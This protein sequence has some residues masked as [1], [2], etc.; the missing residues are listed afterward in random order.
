MCGAHHLLSSSLSASHPSSSARLQDLG[1][2]SGLWKKEGPSG[3]GGRHGYVCLIVARL[4]L[5]LVGSDPEAR[6]GGDIHCI[7]PTTTTKQP[8]DGRHGLAVLPAL[9]LFF[10]LAVRPGCVVPSLNHTSRSQAPFHCPPSHFQAPPTTDLQ[11]IHG[12]PVSGPGS[13]DGQVLYV[14]TTPSCRRNECHPRSSLSGWGGVG[15][16]N[17]RG[18]GRDLAVPGSWS[19]PCR[20]RRATGAFFPLGG[21]AEKLRGGPG[22]W[23]TG[24]PC[25]RTRIVAARGHFL[26]TR[27][28]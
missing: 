21:G 3:E 19:P 18:I 25:K 1:V 11:L 24:A 6:R 17:R 26:G 5:C 7:C 28:M 9:F 16:S 15:R 23:T 20:R 27:S 2:P 14:P 13:T 22:R 4:Q 8:D 10:F 12:S